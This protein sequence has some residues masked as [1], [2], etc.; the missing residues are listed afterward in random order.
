MM[1]EIVDRL[2]RYEK[3]LDRINE[4]FCHGLNEDEEK[5]LSEKR[6]RIEKKIRAISDN[7]GFQVRFNYDPREAAIRFILPDGS[8]NSR[9][10]ETWGLYW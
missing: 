5:V 2:H 6:A 3:K 7:L 4:A 8:S 10:R 1:E 9:N